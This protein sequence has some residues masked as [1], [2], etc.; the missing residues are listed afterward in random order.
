MA[1]KLNKDYTL[2]LLEIDY[3]I[4]ANDD[5]FNELEIRVDFIENIL[6]AEG[7]L[8]DSDEYEEIDIITISDVSKDNQFEEIYC[9]NNN[10]EMFELIINFITELRKYKEKK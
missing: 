3:F 10:I 9:E 6:D 1:I 4:E 8:L 2:T 5:L 7:N